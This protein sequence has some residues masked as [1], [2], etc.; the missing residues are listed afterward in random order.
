MPAIIITETQKAYIRTLKDQNFN[1]HQISIKLGLNYNTVKAFLKR[2]G[3]KH[4]TKGFSEHAT[5]LDDKLKVLKYKSDRVHSK[6]D[7]L[8]EGSTIVLGYENRGKLIKKTGTVTAK[9]PD[10][11]MMRNRHGRLEM[12]TFAD[13]MVMQMKTCEVAL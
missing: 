10:K 3:Y 12:V 7:A 9:Y 8:K 11:F 1:T 5:N 4:V 6:L 2:D 13:L